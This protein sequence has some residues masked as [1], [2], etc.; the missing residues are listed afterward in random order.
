MII[1]FL[2]NLLHSSVT[3]TT[4]Q[5][6]RTCDSHEKYITDELI[7]TVTLMRSTLLMN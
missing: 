7:L 4:S 5:R 1:T 3:E 2:I 6:I